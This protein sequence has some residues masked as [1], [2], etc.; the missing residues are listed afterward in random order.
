MN[1][2]RDGSGTEDTF[3]L[4]DGSKNSHILT[5]EK[6]QQN[7]RITDGM[8]QLLTV[9]DEMS[10][11][12]F[13][14]SSPGRRKFADI[15]M[16]PVRFTQRKFRA[17]GTSGSIFSLVAATLGAGT[18][19]FP[20]A[21]MQNGIAWGSIL[22]VLGAMISYYTGMLLV[23][24]SN[25]TNRHRYEDHA[26]ILFGRKMAIFTSI[27]NLFC[28][29]GFIMSYIVYFGILFPI[30]LPRSINQLRFSSVFGVLCSVYLCIAVIILFWTNKALVPDPIENWREARYFRVNIPQIYYE[31][32]RRNRKQMSNV[33][34]KGSGAA[35]ILYALIGIFG[36]LTFVNTPGQPTTNILEAPY[37]KNGNFT[38]FF[39]VLTASPLCVL[40]TKDTVEE[41]FFKKT[42]LNKKTNIL[43]TLGIV[44]VCYF[45]AIFIGNIG[46]AITIFGCTTNPMVK[47]DQP[48]FCKEKILA[49][50][51]GLLIIVVSI[52]GLYDFIR[53]KVQG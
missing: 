13:S 52:L 30:S 43:V 26:E 1:Q 5:N 21:I 10:K 23:I 31:L 2:Q 24:V 17:G 16:S 38:L 42:G 33:L 4:G 12:I 9:E 11:P 7:S 6:I 27:M 28:L 18:L 47:Q 15:M 29:M 8:K 41:L 39:A 32:E 19:T 36:Y 22:V 34:L 40:P 35:V 49:Y 45:P 53:Q 3:L 20:Y 44:V 51:V 37:Q 50:I 25:H 46:D 48:R 14:P